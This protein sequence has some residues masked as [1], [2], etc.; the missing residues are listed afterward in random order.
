MKDL[1]HKYTKLGI[2]KVIDHDK[3]N[4][5]S[6]VH[7]STSLEGSTLTEVET[8]VLIH[9]G[10]TPKGK[11]LEH[12]L[13]ASDHYAALQYILDQANKRTQVSIPLI[14]AIGAKVLKSTGTLYETIFGQVES[15]NQPTLSVLR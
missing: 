8:S 10:L 11:P 3:F 2:D 13:M 14:Q 12:S 4:Y 7:H 5:I 15:S 1:I 9:H 6:I